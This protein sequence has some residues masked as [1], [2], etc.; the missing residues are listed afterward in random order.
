MGEAL[1]TAFILIYIGFQFFQGA[2][3]NVLLC[4]QRDDSSLCWFIADG[5]LLCVW[6]VWF[7]RYR[8]K[9][10]WTEIGFVP[11]LAIA[12]TL[13]LAMCLVPR[14]SL[15]AT[16]P[17]RGPSDTED[18][19]NARKTCQAV[20]NVILPMIGWTDRF[21]SSSTVSVLAISLTI[22]LISLTM[23]G[24]AQHG[25][26][27]K[28]SLKYNISSALFAV[29]DG[30]SLLQIIFEAQPHTAFPAAPSSL[31]DSDQPRSAALVVNTSEEDFGSGVTSP[32]LIDS[33][34]VVMICPNGNISNTTEEMSKYRAALNGSFGTFILFIAMCNFCVPIF[35]LWQMKRESSKLKADENLNKAAWQKVLRQLTSTSLKPDETREP[36]GKSAKL[37]RNRSVFRRGTVTMATWR[38]RG[39]TMLRRLAKKRAQQESKVYGK[40]QRDIQALST[41]HSLWDFFILN[42]PGFIIRVLAWTVYEKDISVLIVKNMASIF[43]RFL[44]FALFT[45]Q[46]WYRRW[47]G[48][49]RRQ[50]INATDVADLRKYA[51]ATDDEAMPEPH[52]TSSVPLDAIE[53]E[54]EDDEQRAASN[55]GISF[56]PSSATP[57]GAYI[58]MVEADLRHAGIFMFHDDSGYNVGSPSIYDTPVLV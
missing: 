25:L 2:G 19:I 10:A 9:L 52:T 28:Y 6:V 18:G 8:S 23:S 15:L 37:G 38:K 26:S 39:K 41:L 35:G 34:T 57:P 42:L 11:L 49:H 50:S 48:L 58:D 45:V 1:A 27:S 13:Y 3:L 43:F 40:I 24:H 7:A 55:G 44:S 51:M 47:R 4:T 21:T 12:Y 56:F 30:I 22:M 33:H 14:V 20:A 5:I 36:S 32:P 16:P 29:M 31:S 53:E 17:E 46:P 54:N